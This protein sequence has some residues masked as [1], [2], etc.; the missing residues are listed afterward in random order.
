MPT[1]SVVAL[2][3]MKGHSERVPNKNLRLLGG[4]PLYHHAMTALL[5]CSAID[6]VVINT[7]S[8]VIANDV[9]RHF[10]A[11]AV[12]VP[13]PQAICGDF[14]SMNV[15]IDYDLTQVEGEVFLQ[16]HSTNPF[17]TTETIGRAI[18]QFGTPGDHDS[19]FAVTPL[20]V[21]CYDIE[22]RPINHDPR[23]MLRTQDLPP[24]YMENSNLYIFSRESFRRV[25]RRIGDRPLLFEMSK[26][27]SVDID[28]EA[29]FRIAE[30]LMTMAS[31][32]GRS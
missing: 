31:G 27:E 26:L 6:R 24:V 8:D 29:D 7:D 23:E 28:D 16:T 22:G 5:E 17:L 3:P 15:I 2:M 19:V 30:A 20:H 32:G 12:V 11:R 10:G 13:R 18:D 25:G 9:Q 21:R 1:P 14:V 4:R